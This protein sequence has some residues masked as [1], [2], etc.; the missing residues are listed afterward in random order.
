[1]LR[2]QLV[3]LNQRLERRLPEQRLFLRSD[4]TTRFV[5][6]RPMTQLVGIASV[7]AFF[8]WGVLATSILLMDSVGSGTLREQAQREQANY[9]QRLNQMALERDRHAQSAEA[10]QARFGEAMARIADMQVQLLASEQR[11]M[12][13]KKGIDTVQDTV[14]RV[15]RERDAARKQLAEAR[16][17]LEA[18]TG[19]ARTA[20][21]RERDVQDM[22]DYLLVAMENV[23]QDLHTQSVTAEQTQNQAQMLALENE[24]LK[25]RNHVIFSQLETALDSVIG[26]LE[27][28]FRAANVSP[29]Q[30]RR[31]VRQGASSQ[32]ASLRPISVSTS[33]AMAASPDISRAN[34]VLE[35]LN[36]VQAYRRGLDR[37][38]IAHPVASRVRMTSPYGMRRHPVSGRT[39]MH[40]GLDWAAARGTPILSTGD[41]VVKKAGRM[42]GYGNIVI[43]QHDFGLETYYAH[44]NSINVREG[45]RVSRGQ[46]IGGMG[47]TGVSTGV[48][49]HYEVRVNGQPVN[50]ITYVR[51]GQNVF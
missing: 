12:E 36:T 20:A 50:P 49:L 34:R 24:L 6:L 2:R 51:A 23:G 42:G 41:G 26:P 37:L 17:T 45:Q 40:T 15:V 8:A 5:R 9:E 19:T 10:A 7:A 16:Q 1:M 28:V 13:L 30:I 48:H 4:N 29:D 3:R 33:G 11:R 21:D 27:R 31:L 46:K 14:S 25:D 39:K 18:E 38:P 43:I 35:K 22:L 47:T 32:S 44:L